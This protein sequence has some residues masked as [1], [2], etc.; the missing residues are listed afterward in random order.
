MHN[1]ATDPNIRSFAAELNAKFPPSS[2]PQGN[3]S[4]ADEGGEESSPREML[5]RDPNTNSQRSILES[6]PGTLAD[7][8]ATSGRETSICRPRAIPKSTALAVAC[9]VSRMGVANRERKRRIAGRLAQKNLRTFTVL[10]QLPNPDG[11]E[12]SAF[13]VVVTKPCPAPSP[14]R[15]V[16]ISRATATGSRSISSGTGLMDVSASYSERKSRT[17]LSSNSIGHSI[18]DST[19][20]NTSGLGTSLEALNGTMLSR[21]APAVN[22]SMS[23][24]LA[25]D[26][27][28]T[29]KEFSERALSAINHALKPLSD[30]REQAEGHRFARDHF[31]PVDTFLSGENSCPASMR[32]GD[33]RVRESFA[34]EP[35]SNRKVRFS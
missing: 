28:L 22:E 16:D 15:P 24:V 7:R 9:T 14:H 35:S 18:H 5:F 32:A 6:T 20:G 30:Q 34:P 10:T 4:F 27:S 17:N 11:K 1:T 29:A 3:H 31:T 25:I 19:M 26:R 13:R 23:S 21:R 8:S 12:P 2:L 33:K